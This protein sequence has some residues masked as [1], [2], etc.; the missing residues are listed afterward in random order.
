MRTEVALELDFVLAAAHRHGVLARHVLIER[1]IRLYPT[2]NCQSSKHVWP[3]LVSMSG[4][5]DADAVRLVAWVGDVVLRHHV[6]A[7]QP[8]RRPDV[9]LRRDVAKLL[10][11]CAQTA[12][13][14]ATVSVEDVAYG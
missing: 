7:H 14:I 1:P 2:T 4:T 3:D 6:V 5:H 9:Q 10:E 13:A 8:V 11:L 12:T